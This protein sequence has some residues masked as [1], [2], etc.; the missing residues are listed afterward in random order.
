MKLFTVEVGTKSNV[1][2]REMI[3][4][5]QISRYDHDLD[6]ILVVDEGSVQIKCFRCKMDQTLQMVEENSKSPCCLDV[7]HVYLFHIVFQSYSKVMERL[8]L[9]NGQV[10]NPVS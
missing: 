6:D 5:T 9:W 3:I 8:F 1:E 2:V 4:P 7:N 10:N